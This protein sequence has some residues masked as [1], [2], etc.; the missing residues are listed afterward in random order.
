MMVDAHDS[1][2]EGFWRRMASTSRSAAHA[3][4]GE[5]RMSSGKLSSSS[6]AASLAAAVL[7]RRAAVAAPP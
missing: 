5:G 4:E 2:I 7:G 6:S 3:I 1:S